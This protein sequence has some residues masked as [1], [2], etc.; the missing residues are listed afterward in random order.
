MRN[1][2]DD[3]DLDYDRTWTNNYSDGKTFY[4]YDDE[5]GN[6]A[7]YDEDGNLDC[8]TATPTEDEQDQNYAGY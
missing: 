3:S 2:F 6:T 4:G 1:F 8:V 5:D 7:W